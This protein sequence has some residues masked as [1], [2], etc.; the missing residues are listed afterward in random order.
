MTALPC[1]DLRSDVHEV[2]DDIWLNA[3]E[4]GGYEERRL[5][6]LRGKAGNHVRRSARERVYAWLAEQMWLLPK[7]CHVR[8]FTFDQCMEAISLLHGTTYA[9]IRAWARQ[10]ERDRAWTDYC[11]RRQAA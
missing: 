3:V 11:E 9:E 7:D 1:H 5:R 6:V 4:T 2:L 8:R 10:R